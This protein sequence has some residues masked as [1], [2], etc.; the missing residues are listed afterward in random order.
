L[1][2]VLST[3]VLEAVLE[4]RGTTVKVEILSQIAD[5]GRTRFFL[6]GDPFQ[7]IFRFAG[8][9]PDLADAFASHIGARRDFV[10]S[11]NFRSSSP[12]VAHA[13]LLYPR[14]PD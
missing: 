6:T 7:S 2:S 3:S 10:L 9:R 8:A 1:G 4:G 5:A 14:A 13:N 11:G 12:I